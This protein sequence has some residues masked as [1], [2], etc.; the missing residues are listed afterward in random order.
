MREL[1]EMEFRYPVQLEIQRAIAKALTKADEALVNLRQQR[2]TL[3][4]EKQ[5][6]MQQLLTGKRRLA[7]RESTHA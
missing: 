1:R 4:I 5:A 7:I 6:L 2:H 3:V